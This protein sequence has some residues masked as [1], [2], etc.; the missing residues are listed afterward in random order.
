RGFYFV[1]W[2][3]SHCDFVMDRGNVETI[4]AF[5][6]DQRPGTGDWRR[7]AWI[8]G[9]AHYYSGMAKGELYRESCIG[10]VFI[11]HTGQVMVVSGG[12]SFFL[13]LCV[14]IETEI[15]I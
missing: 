9:G 12:S 7:N 15:S 4:N 10:F 3:C 8:I 11:P 2:I 1:G 5:S 13:I 14:T 6:D